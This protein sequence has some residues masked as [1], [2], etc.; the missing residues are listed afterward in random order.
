MMEKSVILVIVLL[1]QA[2]VNAVDVLHDF[3]ATAPCGFRIRDVISIELLT[4]ALAL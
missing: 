1:H 3:T 4:C 2:P